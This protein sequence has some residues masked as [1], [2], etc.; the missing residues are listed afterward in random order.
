MNLIFHSTK[1]W[2]GAQLLQFQS[3]GGGELQP[4]Q[5]SFLIPMVL[6]C[7]KLC[8]CGHSKLKRANG[9]QPCTSLSVLSSPFNGCACHLMTYYK[10]LH[11]HSNPTLQHL[12]SIQKS[13]CSPRF[14]TWF[15]TP[16]ATPNTYLYQTR[17]V[18]GWSTK[19]TYCRAYCSLLG[20]RHTCC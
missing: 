4:P 2:V 7:V 3:W 14:C 12:V 5:P 8:I 6:G 16:I 11:Y 19:L 17:V 1:L 20:L 9:S 18:M 15:V 13:H 10:L